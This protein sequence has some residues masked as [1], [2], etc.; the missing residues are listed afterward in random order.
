MIE[1]ID[2]TELDRYMSRM[3]QDNSELFSKINSIKNDDNELQELKKISI[4]LDILERYMRLYNSGL[5]S[6]RDREALLYMIKMT[7]GMLV[8]ECRDF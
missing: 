5:L 6:D 4:K 1:N 2:G 7:F 8:Q 3:S